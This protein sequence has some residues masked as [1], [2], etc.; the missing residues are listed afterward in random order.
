MDGL[1]IFGHNIG[2]NTVRNGS[3]IFCTFEEYVCSL[4]LYTCAY[5]S[6]NSRKPATAEEP[7]LASVRAS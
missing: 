2:Y 7:H 3:E 5:N 6:R 1:R 4:F